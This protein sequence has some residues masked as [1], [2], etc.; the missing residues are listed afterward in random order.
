[1]GTD[2]WAALVGVVVPG[3][4]MRDGEIHSISLELAIGPPMFIWRE[5]IVTG[6]RV[7]ESD[8]R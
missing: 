8:K 4:R 6:A 3:S 2:Q 5:G 7:C 1:M